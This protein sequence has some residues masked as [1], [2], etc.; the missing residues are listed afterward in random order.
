LGRVE[1]IA[2]QPVA[3]RRLPAGKRREE[4]R[5]IRRVPDLRLGEDAVV[6]GD[7]DIGRERVPEPATHHP[8]VD[9]GD[10]RLR[11]V[12]EVHELERR[13]AIARPPPMDVFGDL[14]PGGVERRAAVRAARDVEPGRGAAA[15]AGEDDGADLP[16]GVGVVERRL[17]LLGHLRIDRVER[18]GPVEGDR[19][20]RAVLLVEDRLVGHRVASLFDYASSISQSTATTPRPASRTRRGL[21]SRARSACWCASASAANLTIASA[22]ASTS[23]GARPRAPRRS[24]APRSSSTMAIASARPTGGT[25][26]DTSRSCSTKIP[27]NPQTTAGPKSGSVLTPRIISVP[28]ATIRCTSAPSRRA[29]GA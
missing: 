12:P 21:M 7:G 17:E 23:A 27:P 19:Q 24:A 4:E 1:V 6:R 28:P 14:D 5:R 20:H 18:L 8:T 9:G 11:D 13:V 10:D 25:R 16:V 15:G 2:G 3:V 29:D 26:T 22:S